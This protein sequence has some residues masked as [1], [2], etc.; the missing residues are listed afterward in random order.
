MSVQKSLSDLIIETIAN[1]ILCLSEDARRINFTLI[2]RGHSVTG[3]LCLRSDWMDKLGRPGLMPVIMETVLTYGEDEIV[4]PL[5]SDDDMATAY[6]LLQERL[7][8]EKMFF[9]DNEQGWT[10]TSFKS[11]PLRQSGKKLNKAK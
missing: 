6:D 9:F 3:P 10:L 1:G 7:A 11:K 8:P 4:L 5:P 2:H